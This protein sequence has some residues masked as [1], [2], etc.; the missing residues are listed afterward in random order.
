MTAGLA[1]DEAASVR[2]AGQAYLA[3]IDR[4]TEENAWFAFARARDRIVLGR[5]GVEADEPLE[6]TGRPDESPRPTS[7]ANS[8]AAHE[9]AVRAAVDRETA[10]KP[11]GSLLLVH[12][13]RA[14]AGLGKADFDKAAL[15]L[16]RKGE[17]VLHHHDHPMALPRPER[18]QLIEDAERGVHYIGMAKRR[19]APTHTSPPHDKRR[20]RFAPAF[21]SAFAALSPGRLLVKLS[22]L[23]AALPE[24]DRASFDRGLDEL[25]DADRYVLHTF[26]GR[27]GAITAADEAAAIREGGRTFVY[28][29]RREAPGPDDMSGG[30]DP[31]RAARWATAPLQDFARR[32]ND[33]ARELNGWPYENGKKFS[34]GVKKVFIHRV[35]E[36]APYLGART[37]GSR[38]VPSLETFKN[39]LLD[40]HRKGLVEL[41]RADLV[42]AMRAEDDRESEIN[43]LNLPFNFIRLE[44]QTAWARAAEAAEARLLKAVDD[45]AATEPPGALLGVKAVRARAGLDKKAFDDAALRLAKK[46]VIMLHH[47]D[48]P[49]SLSEDER[50]ELIHEPHAPNH[51]G[52]NER[53]ELIEDGKGVYYVGIARRRT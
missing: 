15:V 47:H 39:R 16:A 27:H 26:D 52:T 29:V 17:L 3:T 28:V 38:W 23:R 50:G 1:D 45:E 40:A 41:S 53:A 35:H 43:Y 49:T 30:L 6:G 4:P 9:A 24:F 22:D 46:R 14:A 37:E 8:P 21:E 51:I 34:L 48:F 19:E 32:V 7:R 2:A 12:D 44:E 5:A 20:S 11:P 36:A 13:V 25:R 18:E 10:R 31:V 33:V 42:E